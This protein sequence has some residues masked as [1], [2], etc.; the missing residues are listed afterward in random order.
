MSYSSL[1]PALTMSM[2]LLPLPLPTSASPRRAFG[3][4]IKGVQPGRLSPEEFRA[5]EEALYKVEFI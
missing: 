1:I 3:Q 2:E 5:V 4:E